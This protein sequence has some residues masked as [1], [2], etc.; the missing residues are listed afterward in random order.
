MSDAKCYCILHIDVYQGKNAANTGIAPALVDLGTTQKA[1]MNAVYSLGLQNDPRSKR[2]HI[3]MDNRYQCAE[4]ALLLREQANIYSTG[5]V[6]AN[7][8]RMG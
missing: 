2:H 1:M 5:T 3:A 8:K 7:C 4:L 6:H